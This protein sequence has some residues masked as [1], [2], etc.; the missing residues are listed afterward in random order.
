MGFMRT[1]AKMSIKMAVFHKK[2]G[3]VKRFKEEIIKKLNL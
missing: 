2:G 1:D 3:N